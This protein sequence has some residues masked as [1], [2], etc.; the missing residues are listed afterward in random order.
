MGLF[1]SRFS[2]GWIMV[3]R[4]ILGAL[5]GMLAS[6][7]VL[8]ADDSVLLHCDGWIEN[9]RKERHGIADNVQI[10]RDGSWIMWVGR[11]R[12]RT[13][14]QPKG[15]EW[16]YRFKGLLKKDEDIRFDPTDMSL[17]YSGDNVARLYAC[18]PIENPF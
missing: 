17:I 11:K 10:A 8:A 5:V 7:P 12:S 18:F 2:T 13:G 15:G 16:N 3:K 9:V 4:I 14:E 6:W 1:Y